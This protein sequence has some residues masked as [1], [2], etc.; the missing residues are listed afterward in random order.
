MQNEFLERQPGYLKRQLLKGQG[1]SYVDLVWWASMAEA[2]AAMAKV[3]SSKAC[4]KYFSHMRSDQTEAGSGVLHL[5]AV[6]IYRPENG[7]PDAASTNGV[8]KIG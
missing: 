1:E 8:R 2:E 3:S 7:Q 6:R 4:A 5:E